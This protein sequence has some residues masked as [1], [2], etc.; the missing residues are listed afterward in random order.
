MFEDFATDLIDV[1]E[2]IRISIHT[3]GADPPLLLL[4]GFPQRHFCWHK[5]ASHLAKRFTVVVTD[6]RGYGA[7]SKVVA[8]QALE[9]RLLKNSMTGDG[10]QEGMRYRASEKLEINRIVEQSHLPA[11]RMLEKFGILPVSF[12]RWYDRSQNGGPEA[13]IRR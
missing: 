11:R 7:S 10:G 8:E 2:G 12:Y 13:F 6:L 9:L 4:H 1:G 3:A 5:I